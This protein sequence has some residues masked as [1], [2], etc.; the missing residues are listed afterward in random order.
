MDSYLTL[1]NFFY[2]IS[3]TKECIMDPYWNFTIILPRTYASTPAWWYP[4]DE[5]NCDY[6]CLIRNGL[7]A[8][9]V[10]NALFR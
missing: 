5:G 2:N 10:Y 3:L 4:R 1:A 7:V 6:V 9:R 8:I